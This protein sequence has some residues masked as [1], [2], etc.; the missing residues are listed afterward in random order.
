MFHFRDCKLT[1]VSEAGS[2]AA[3][4]FVLHDAQYFT[5]AVSEVKRL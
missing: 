4:H 3:G 5:V 1:A 2:G